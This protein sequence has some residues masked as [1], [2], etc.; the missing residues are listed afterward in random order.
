[1]ITIVEKALLSLFH[2]L[3]SLLFSFAMSYYSI[4]GMFDFAQID[5]EIRTNDRMNRFTD[6]RKKLAAKLFTRYLNIRSII[7]S[8]ASQFPI[9]AAQ[10]ISLF[11]LLCLETRQIALRFLSPSSRGI[12]P[13][14]APL[15]SRRYPIGDQ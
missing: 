7:A 1:M 8:A 13:E 4:R 5:R 2:D 6:L 12:M 9:S 14:R 15:R 3:F 10:S 11:I